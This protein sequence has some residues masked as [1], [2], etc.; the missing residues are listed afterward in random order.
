MELLKP[1]S[2]VSLSVP[3]SV[4]MSVPPLFQHSVDT[5]HSI[6]F[7]SYL[8][9]P[10]FHS[11]KPFM[12]YGTLNLSGFIKPAPGIIDDLNLSEIQSCF[13]QLK[14]FLNLS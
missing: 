8:S 1:S 10:A 2:L 3:P 11:F 5:I 9:L 13:R 14:I 6:P 4:S 12:L 7:P